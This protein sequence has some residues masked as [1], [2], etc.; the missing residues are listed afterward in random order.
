MHLTGNYKL[1]IFENAV[2]KLSY[3][4]FQGKKKK[5]YLE[6]KIDELASNSEIKN[7][8][9]MHRGISDFKKGYQPRTNIVN[10]DRSDLVTESQRILV[11]WRNHCSQL[12]NLHGVSDVSRQN[13]Y[14]RNT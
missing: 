11:R 2:L 5:E 13:T 1:Q 4:E 9:D 10:D 14:S 3:E 6:A 7:V 8:R 12:L